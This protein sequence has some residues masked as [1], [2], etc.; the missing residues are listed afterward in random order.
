[1]STKDTISRMLIYSHR[2]LGF[3]KLENSIQALQAALF[4]TVDG[5]EF[6]VRLTKDHKWVTLH[7]PFFKSEERS[8]LRVHTKTYNQIKREVTLLDTM[9]ALFATHSKEKLLMI[10]VKDVGEEKQLVRMIQKYDL[11]DQITIIAW[12]PE[13]LRRVYARDKDIK[14][15]FSY[16]PI[17]STLTF[18]KGRAKE[19]LSRYKVVM[20]FNAMHRFDEKFSKGYSNQHYLSTIPDLP[21]ASIQVFA[22]FC[23]EKL[24]KRAH[25]KGIKVMPFVVNT[26]LMTVLLRRR[27]V[28]GILTNTPKTFLK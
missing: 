13:I 19:P 18:V 2:C 6:D 16:I 3:G 27:G 28:D 24:V 23:T 9:L 10:D 20:N 11:Y 22:P 15:G 4:S 14:L 26:R 5:I 1:M 25:E 12:E 21:L 8:V 7:N 17:H